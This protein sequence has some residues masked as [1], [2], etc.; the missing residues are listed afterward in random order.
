[1]VSRSCFSTLVT[2]FHKVISYAFNKINFN[3]LR[4]T[5]LC[6]WCIIHS[7]KTCVSSAPPAMPLISNGKQN[8]F[9]VMTPWG[10]G[11]KSRPSEGGDKKT[12]V[13]VWLVVCLPLSADNL[14]NA[15]NIYGLYVT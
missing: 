2:Y 6:P 4:L 9:D 14:A 11:S 1:M 12:A 3:G 7:I 15:V 5:A 8:R 10:R 13:D